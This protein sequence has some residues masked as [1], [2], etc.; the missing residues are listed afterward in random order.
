MVTYG[1]RLRGVMPIEYKYG[2]ITKLPDNL[3][4]NI[5]IREKIVK[6]YEQC[7]FCHSEH[8]IYVKRSEWRKSLTSPWW[9]FWKMNYCLKLKFTCHDCGAEWETPW[10]PQDIKT[11]EIEYD[12]DVSIDYFI[13]KYGVEV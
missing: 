13:K 7:P 1:L 5:L 3:D 9:Q 11:D 10:F 8:T 2:K 6:E 4:P 12:A